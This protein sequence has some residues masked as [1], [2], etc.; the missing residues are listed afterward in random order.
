[1][2]KDQIQLRIKNIEAE[3]LKLRKEL[4]AIEKAENLFEDRGADAD[5]TFEE[6]NDIVTD[7]FHPAEFAVRTGGKY[8]YNGIFLG[9]DG[10]ECPWEIIRDEEDAWVLVLTCNK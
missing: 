10:G 3:I 9:C 6:V 7:R 1:M 2:N 8:A 4:D 5:Y